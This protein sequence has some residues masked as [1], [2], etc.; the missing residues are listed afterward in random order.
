V[1][2]YLGILFTAL[3]FSG[4]ATSTPKVT[5]V[6]PMPNLEPTA[7]LRIMIM[8]GVNAKVTLNKNND[9]NSC[10]IEDDAI[11]LP[12]HINLSGLF[13]KSK[14]RIG[15]PT[16]GSFLEKAGSEMYIPADKPITL[17]SW[18]RANGD[19]II[20]SCKSAIKFTPEKSK[21]YQIFVHQGQGTTYTTGCV[22]LKEIHVDKDQKIEY[23]EVRK[24]TIAVKGSPYWSKS[25]E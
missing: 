23:L 3:L 14:I 24:E 13:N 6:Q 22:D 25:C 21:D 11:S 2:K 9:K 19:T 15:M 7:R 12:L 5:Y 1:N 17:A 20:H 8:P 16:E 18:S 10:L 4:C